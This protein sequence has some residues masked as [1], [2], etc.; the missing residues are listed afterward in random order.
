ME[1]FAGSELSVGFEFSVERCSEL[2]VERDSELLANFLPEILEESAQR[3]TKS[4][5]DLLAGCK[6][7]ADLLEEFLSQ[8]LAGT[9]LAEAVTLSAEFFTGSK[10]L[11]Q[12]G[13]KLFTQLSVVSIKAGSLLMAVDSLAYRGYF[14]FKFTHTVEGWSGK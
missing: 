9:S 7:L 4:L 12:A 11:V 6:I 2:S 14:D 10:L 3:S 1:R 8:L 5:L 13:F